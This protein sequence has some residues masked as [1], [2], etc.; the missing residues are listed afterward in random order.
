MTRH[1]SLWLTHKTSM[2]A[3]CCTGSLQTT[4]AQAQYM[5]CRI[6]I[7]KLLCCVSDFTKSV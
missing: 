2:P 5:H 7:G 1:P 4:E 6:C 3:K